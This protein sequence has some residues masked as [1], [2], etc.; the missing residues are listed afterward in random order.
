M[1]FIKRILNTKKIKEAKE[2]ISQFNDKFEISEKFEDAKEVVSD[3]TE[4]AGDKIE[5]VLNDQISFKT[6]S[7]VEMRVGEI[8]EV[9]DV[10][11]SDKLLK[12][13]V[14]FGAGDERQIVA[15][16]KRSYSADY[17]SGKKAIFVTNMEPRTIMGLES[18]GMI[19]GISQ[20]DTFSILIPENQEII[21]GAKAS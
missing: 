9:E 6:F 14:S 21:A 8:L 5:A 16:I 4:K 15:G 12:L 13:R 10:E 7:K 3:M 19:L 1:N 11:G 20:G 18:N 17:L 2:K